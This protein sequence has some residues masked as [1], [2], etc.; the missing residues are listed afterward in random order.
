MSRSAHSIR[1][2]PS[3]ASD[4]I[5]DVPGRAGQR[6]RLPMQVLLN[7]LKTKRYQDE[8]QS[9]YSS[10]PAGRHHATTL[11]RE[12]DPPAAAIG[13]KRYRAGRGSES[14]Q[15][16]LGTSRRSVLRRS[17]SIQSSGPGSGSGRGTACS[18][19]REDHPM[20]TGLRRSHGGVA[21][22]QCF[23][24]SPVGFG[25]RHPQGLADPFLG[26]E[27]MQGTQPPLLFGTPPPAQPIAFHASHPFVAHDVPI[28]SPYQRRDAT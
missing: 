13:R 17:Q 24:M 12:I 23:E 20:G 25:H 19:L 15:E 28:R 1:F 4:K 3:S 9:N 18:R 2:R 5:L 11:E 10:R 16:P 6:S 7:R 26:Q 21:G 8:C 22:H 27:G 14:T